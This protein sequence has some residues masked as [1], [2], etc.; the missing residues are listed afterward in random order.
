MLSVTVKG[1]FAEGAIALLM[2]LQ[3]FYVSIIVLVLCQ[4][5]Y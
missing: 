2:V 4:G 5:K 3:P 1:H